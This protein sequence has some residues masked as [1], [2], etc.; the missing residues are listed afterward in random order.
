MI[1]LVTFRLAAGADEAAVVAADHRVQT[2]FFYLQRG[3]A[4]RTTARGTDGEWLVVTLWRSAADADAA[5]LAAEA[6]PAA[7]AF[8]RCIDPATYQT[9]RYTALD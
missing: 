7:Q 6:D 3:L 5:A 8:M 1:E 2:E 4:R 9:K